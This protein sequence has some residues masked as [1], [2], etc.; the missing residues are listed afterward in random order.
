MAKAYGSS[1][2]GDWPLSSSLAGFG[3]D[4][5]GLGGLHFSPALVHEARHPRVLAHPGAMERLLDGVLIDYVSFTDALESRLVT[6]TARRLARE[7]SP[8]YELPEQARMD[9]LAVA[10]DEGFHR[11]FSKRALARLAAHGGTASAGV[12]RFD[13]DIATR[14]E[15]LSGLERAVMEAIVTTVTETLITGSLI[16]LPRDPCVSIYVR[17]MATAHAQDEK[18]H[19]AVLSAVLAIIWPQL[20][21]ALKDIAIDIVPHAIRGFLLPD[22]SKRHARLVQ[23]GL[24]SRDA[25]EVLQEVIPTYEGALQRD[26][27]PTVIAFERAGAMA[28]GLCESL[29]T[30]GLIVS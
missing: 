13:S 27:R 11:A 5:E 17:K 4:F 25:D 22:W 26:A 28:D 19:H 20:P 3:W 12:S 15:S 29:I 9:L 21:R 2:M 1:K 16:G 10:G 14:L 6:P 7:S 8:H 24:S 18:H 30:Q 23:A